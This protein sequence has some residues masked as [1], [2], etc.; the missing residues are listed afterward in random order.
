[1]NYY[2]DTEFI[3]DFTRPVFGRP[4]HYTELISIGIVAEDGREYYAVSKD[5]DLKHIWNKYNLLGPL[6]FG[7]EPEKE[8]WLRDNVLRPIWNDLRQNISGDHRLYTSA[9]E[10]FTYKNLKQ[11]I[12]WYGKTNKQIAAE[13]QC[14]TAELPCLGFGAEQSGDVSRNAK[15]RNARGNIDF[16]AYYADYDWVLFCSLFGRML[17][18]PKGYPMYCRD[19]KQTMAELE[20]TRDW[21]DK[22]VPGDNKHNA[23]TDAH[24]NRKLHEAL[25]AEA[26]YRNFPSARSLS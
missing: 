12:T 2:L 10:L 25:K 1:M 6:E 15:E 3:E 16:Y 26:A 17:D 21:K 24:W 9:W 22:Y 20:L 11:L 18:L 13:I 14:F 8:Y 23:L 7:G 5:F 4:K 19:L